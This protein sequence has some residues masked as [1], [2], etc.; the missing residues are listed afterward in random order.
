[1]ENKLVVLN[2]VTEDLDDIIE[3]ERQPNDVI[4]DIIDVSDLPDDDTDDIIEI[5]S[6]PAEED[7]D[8]IIET[9]T[10]SRA[11]NA[12][13]GKVLFSC[14]CC[15][16]IECRN[17]SANP[18][19]L[20]DLIVPIAIPPE[21]VPAEP[22]NLVSQLDQAIASIS[23]RNLSMHYPSSNPVEKVSNIQG[24]VGFVELDQAIAS[25]AEL[26]SSLL[27]SKDSDYDQQG[28]PFF[29]YNMEDPGNSIEDVASLTGIC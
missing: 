3:V 11:V 17:K 14:F 26:Q 9:R 27:G 20:P 8:I 23:N 22:K 12:V 13:Q 25:I 18:P 28:S 1:M 4:D 10:E 6:K 5:C 19:S 29:Q 15:P 7:D 24:G 16:T 2:P 21:P